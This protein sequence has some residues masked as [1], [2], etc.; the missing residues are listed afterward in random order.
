MAMQL[1]EAF[2]KKRENSIPGNRRK[3]MPEFVAAV[4]A[5]KSPRL[6]GALESGLVSTDELVGLDTANIIAKKRQYE[7]LDRGGG[8][9]AS[10]KVN[11]TDTTP[12]DPQVR[13]PA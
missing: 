7:A 10:E 11:G 5:L 3:I 1:S 9:E 6:M 8:F 2:W 4:D 12:R 13:V